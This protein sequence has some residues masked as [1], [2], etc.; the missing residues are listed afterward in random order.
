M[1]HRLLVFALALAGCSGGPVPVGSSQRAPK[2]SMA[3]PVPDHLQGA[4]EWQVR[5]GLLRQDGTD[6]SVVFTRT[7]KVDLDGIPPLDRTAWLG[8]CDNWDEC[9]YA[10]FVRCPNG[11]FRAV[12]GP[13]H[14]WSGRDPRVDPQPNGWAQLVFFAKRRESGCTAIVARRASRI[15]GE[16]D[17]GSP[18]LIVGEKAPPWNAALCGDDKPAACSP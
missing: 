11:R 18:C 4:C 14:V 8:D 6:I 3:P 15:D 16:W 13:E 7:Q 9:L 1:S 10:A 12:W 17:M 5:D 2:P